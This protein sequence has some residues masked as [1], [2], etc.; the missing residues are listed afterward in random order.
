MCN[1]LDCYVNRILGLKGLVIT[2][3]STKIS[4][5]GLNCRL[6]TL[7]SFFKILELN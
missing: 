3:A 6:S 4:G 2:N 1:V 5:I 7:R